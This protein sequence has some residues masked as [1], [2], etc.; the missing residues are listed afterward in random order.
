MRTIRSRRLDAAA[1]MLPTWPEL[2]YESWRETRD[3]LQLWLQIVGK[4]RLAQSPWISHS[5]HVG[6]YVTPTGVT[7]LAIPHGSQ[8]FQID[9]DLNEHRVCVHTSAGRSGSFPLEPQPVRAFYE[10]LMDLLRR[11]EVPVEIRR[12]SN[13]LAQAV[14]LDRDEA[15]RSYDAEYAH[16]FWRVLAQCER[17]FGLF[18]ARYAGK[19]SP[20]QLFWGNMDLAVA[21]F[22]G[23]R[24][25]TH[26]GGRP[27]L[28]DVVLRDAYSH[29]CFE[30]G[31]WPGGP[32]HPAP[33]FFALAYPPPRGYA[34]ARVA[35]ASTYYSSELKEFVLPYDA[36]RDAQSPDEAILAFLQSTYEAAATL[37]HWDRDNLEY[38]A[39]SFGSPPVLRGETI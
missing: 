33:I 1:D 14:R 26:P 20:V 15:H 37:G 36:V 7:T 21:R 39:A 8:L 27:H 17:V 2:S 12:K 23:R 18:R 16:R 4:V 6:T 34:Q 5:W 9:L 29:E 28:P 10:R 22:S 13:E 35:P 31:F 30:C 3:T 19:S 38:A 11:L 24:A 32:E 25:P